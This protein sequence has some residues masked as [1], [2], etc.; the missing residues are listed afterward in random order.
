[1]KTRRF[2]M[3]L[4]ILF[5]L[6]GATAQATNPVPFIS[7]PFFPQTLEPGGPSFVLT[8]EGT[9]FVPT[10]V[11]NWNGTALATAY[12]NSDQLRAAV[13]S[14]YIALTGTA[15]VTVA[16]GGVTSNVAYFEITNAASVS[17][18]SSFFAVGS[19]SSLVAVGDFNGGCKVGLVGAKFDD[20][21]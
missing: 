18:A 4:G 9:G 12:V 2:A 1:M 17:F 19:S 7:Q 11:V 14:S 5:F 13:P 6:A 10:S 20:N 16:N 8:V 3:S 15:S 21:A